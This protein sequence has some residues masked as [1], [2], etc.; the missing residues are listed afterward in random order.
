MTQDQ[1]QAAAGISAGLAA[2]WHPHI[3]AAMQKFSIIKPADQAMFIAQSAHESAGFTALVESLNY[4][5][6]GLSATFGNRLSADQIAML[7][8]QR[9]ESVV[10]PERQRAIAN[11]VYAGRMGN[12][13][14]GDGWNYRGRG[15]IQVTGRNNYKSCGAGLLLDLIKSPEMLEQDQ[16][17]ALSAAWF[18]SSSGCL[19]Y[20]G[21]IER[22][23]LV[24]NGGRNGLDDRRARYDRAMQALS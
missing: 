21:D 19:K 4:S 5:Q 23:T 13:Q 10:P 14:S 6:A 1:F 22:V 12:T 20:S 16:Y 9:N 17:A 24:I 7:G 15:L 8:R 18:Y 11:L 3:T 2:R